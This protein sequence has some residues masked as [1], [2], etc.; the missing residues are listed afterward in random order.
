MSI[1][2][3]GSM[4]LPELLSSRSFPTPNTMVCELHCQ[5]GLDADKWDKSQI[6]PYPEIGIQTFG[7]L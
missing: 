3:I 6:G 5:G 1:F 7:F 4:T 2:A